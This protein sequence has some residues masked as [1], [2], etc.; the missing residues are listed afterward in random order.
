MYAS[1]VLL[2]WSFES[3][4]FIFKEKRMLLKFPTGYFSVVVIPIQ[5]KNA[6]DIYK[7]LCTRMLMTL[8]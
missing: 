4:G 2:I 8:S 6:L 5:E 3:I 1:K 7:P